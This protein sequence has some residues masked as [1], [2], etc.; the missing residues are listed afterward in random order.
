MQEDGWDVSTEKKHTDL[1]LYPF[2]YTH[3][4]MHIYIIYVGLGVRVR[5]GNLNP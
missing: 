1:D 2:I 5:S 4:S 3:I